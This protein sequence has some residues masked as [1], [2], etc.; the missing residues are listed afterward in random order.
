M[1]TKTHENIWKQI[2]THPDYEISVNGDVRRHTGVQAVGRFIPEKFPIKQFT[3]NNGYARVY[4]SKDKKQ[5][6]HTI[7]CLVLETF[8]IPRPTK[9]HQA[10]H[11]DGNKQNN[12]IGNLRWDTAKSNQSDRKKHGTYL[13]GSSSPN[14]VIDEHQVKEIWDYWTNNKITKRDVAKKF[15]LNENTVY[16]ILCGHT[17]KHV[18]G[19]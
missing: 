1:R 4:L 15:R 3:S 19:L 16:H 12:Y 8:D 17:W 9:N 14:S 6:K 10:C 5:K 18:T 7:H 13:C 11:N 2:P